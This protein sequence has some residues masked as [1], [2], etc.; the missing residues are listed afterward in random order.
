MATVSQ[1]KASGRVAIC[2]AIFAGFAYVGYAVVRQTFG[3]R[4]E[5][6]GFFKNENDVLGLEYEDDRNGKVYLRRLSGSAAGRRDVLGS[7][8]NGQNGSIPHCVLRPLSVRER[9]RELNLNA[10]AFADT[11]LAL[12]GRPP[13]IG[14][15]SLGCSPF[16]SPPRILSPLDARQLPYLEYNQPSCPQTPRLSRRASRR[17]LSRRSLASSVVSLSEAQQEEADARAESLLQ[18]REGELTRRLESLQSGKNRE[19]TPYE[20]KSLVALLHS[21]DAEKVQRT[22]TTVANAAAFTRNQDSLREAGVL[23]RLPNLLASTDRAIKEAAVVAAANLSLNIGNM[24]EM[25]QCVTVLILLAEN[26]DSDAGLQLSVLECLTNICVLPDWHQL[27]HPLLAPLINNITSQ[28]SSIRLQSLR[29]LINLVCNNEMLAPVLYSAAPS[30]TNLISANTPDEELLRS[31]TLL[32]NICVSSSRQNLCNPGREHFL[33]EPNSLQTRL[34]QTE[35]GTLLNQALWLRD[36]HANTEI[37][38]QASKILSVLSG[39][40]L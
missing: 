36:N 25:E 7:L 26:C 12:N 23:V 18:G 37:K 10:L 39:L 32:A 21:L 5:R 8:D 35:T 2:S 28:Y 16:H 31:L 11:I 20:C 30:L 34:F 40:Q 3:R 6:P 24:K 17:N 33:A 14:A 15:R 13:V 4:L 22:L 29:L 9:I 1:D 27:F 19:L 38:F